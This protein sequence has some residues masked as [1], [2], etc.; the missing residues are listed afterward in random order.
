MF[1]YM[2]FPVKPRFNIIK[3]LKAKDQF[4]QV[5][6]II[7]SRDFLLIRNLDIIGI[8]RIF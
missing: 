3:N 7:L 6:F 8:V 4:S 5:N 2:N 1:M